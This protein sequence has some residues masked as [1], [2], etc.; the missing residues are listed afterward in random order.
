ML[1]KLNALDPSIDPG[2]IY[3]DA[4]DYSL[5]TSIQPS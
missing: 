5:R 2:P 3:R 1:E 4:I